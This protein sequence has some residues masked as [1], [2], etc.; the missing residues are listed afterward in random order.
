VTS[1][2]A[3]RLAQSLLVLFAVTLLAFVLVYAT[4]DPAKAM[5]PLDAKPEDVAAMRAAFGLDQPIWVQYLRFLERAVAGDLGESL[6]YRTNALQLVIERLPNTLLLATSSVVLAVVIA[7]PLGMLAASRRDSVLDYATTGASILTLSTPTFWLGI[8]LILI[9]ADQLRWLPASGT[10]TWR[11]LVLP[12]VTLAAPSIGLLTRLVRATM[13]DV[14]RQDYIRTARAKGVR[15]R[16]VYLSH[17]LRN[18]L[19]PMITVVGLQFGALLGGT[20]VIESVFAWPG[21]GFLLIQA[22]SGRDLPLIRSAVLVIAVFF[23]A[24]NLTVD[25][26]YGYVDPRIR[27]A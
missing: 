23:V 8:V 13:T 12:A 18:C 11:N 14:L 22:I 24:I 2:A 21:L 7:V 4:G 10:G 1:F 26:L 27:R 16:A 15:W 6:K 25:L 19:I 5:V 20:V 3:L 17:A 9:F